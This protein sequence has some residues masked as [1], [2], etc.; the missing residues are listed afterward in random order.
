MFGSELLARLHN[1]GG[2]GTAH[3]AYAATASTTARRG[4]PR[5]VDHDRP[6]LD[7]SVADVRDAYAW[8]AASAAACTALAA[9][10]AVPSRASATAGAWGAFDSAVHSFLPRVSRA[11]NAA[12]VR[13]QSHVCERHGGLD[14]D[15]REGA[16]SAAPA[17][18]RQS[19]A[20]PRTTATT[21][22]ACAGALVCAPS[23]AATLP[24]GAGSQAGT[25]GRTSVACAFQQAEVEL[26]RS[27]A[28]IAVHAGVPLATIAAR[29]WRHL[30]SF[31]SADIVWPSGVAGC[32]WTA[33]RTIGAAA[34][35]APRHI[36]PTA[37]LKTWVA[38]SDRGCAA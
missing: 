24:R 36:I 30:R 8:S 23:A 9:L 2:P 21:A 38:A 19:T 32:A 26:E 35:E 31:L 16:A 28:G 29:A 3:V 27:G 15:E 6:L 10:S 22:W 20:S 14:R 34:T 17:V 18:A 37:G 4:R 7:R 12:L 33:V 25:A 13:A 1:P 11:A 5:D